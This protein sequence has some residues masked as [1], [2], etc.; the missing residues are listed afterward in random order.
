MRMRRRTLLQGALAAGALGACGRAPRG[1]I[2]ADRRPARSRV[3]VLSAASYAGDLVGLLRSGLRE[4]R[5]KLRGLRVVLKPNFVEF[6]PKGVINTHPLLVAAAA[7]AFLMEGAREVVV[8]EGPGHRRDNEYILTASGLD[9]VLREKRIHYVD[10]NFDHSQ[11]TALGSRFTEF[12]SLYLPRTVM[13]AGLF[14]S[15]PKLKTHHWA[16]VTLSMK[17]LFGTG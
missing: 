17:N 11:F 1:A 6:E 8:A 13:D 14:V 10:L 4:W 16:G 15:M 7:E 12:G 5:L 3:A 9:A 2:G